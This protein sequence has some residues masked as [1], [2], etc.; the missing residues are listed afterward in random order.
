[1]NQIIDKDNFI[2]TDTGEREEWM[3]LADLKFNEKDKTEQPCV[4]QTDSHI[5]EDRSFYTTE[6]IGDMPHW[7]DQQKN[8][9]IQQTNA[10]PVPIEI[11]QRVAFSIIRDHFLGSTND[12]LFMILTGL[13]GSGKS[14]VIQAVTNL[15]N[16]QCK[17][18]AYF[19]I[20]AFNIKGTTLHS[21][22]QLPIRGKK[23]TIKIICFGKVAR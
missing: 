8:A 14:F 20:A 23:W 12:Q 6:Q 11:N 18:C 13:G 16:E 19:G 3:I 7:I 17:V 21:L 1:M 9:I 15:L 5:A 10:T 2:E 4:N 22:L